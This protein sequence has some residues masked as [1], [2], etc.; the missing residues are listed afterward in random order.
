MLNELSNILSSAPKGFNVLE[1]NDYIIS[2]PRKS[3]KF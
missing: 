1:K 3:R 2:Q